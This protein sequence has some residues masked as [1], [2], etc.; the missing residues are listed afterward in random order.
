MRENQCFTG[1]S[2]T[3]SSLLTTFSAMGEA[4]KIDSRLERLLPLK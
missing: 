4:K 1:M 3:K 2:N